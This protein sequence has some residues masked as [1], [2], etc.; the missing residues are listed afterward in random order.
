MMGE[1]NGP[2]SPGRMTEHLNA[3][4]HPPHTGPAPIQDLSSILP[5]TA[6]HF[7][8]DLDRAPQAI[9]AFR[10]AA[11]DIRDLKREVS[12]LAHIAAPGFD[13]VS[14]NAAREIGQWALI[15]EPGSLRSALESGAIQLEKTADALERS[16]ATHRNIDE[17]ATAQLSWLEQ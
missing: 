10:Q 17:A 7:Q 5:G 14:I 15:E 9:T 8:L 12:R 11:Q 3:L 4:L 6:H 13:A 2:A 16:L 1:L